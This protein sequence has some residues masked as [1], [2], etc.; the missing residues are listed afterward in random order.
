MEVG[1]RKKYLSLKN[2]ELIMEKLY[3]SMDCNVLYS[4]WTS[5]HLEIINRF[6]PM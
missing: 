5:G 6:Y 4:I 3:F 1:L 2:R